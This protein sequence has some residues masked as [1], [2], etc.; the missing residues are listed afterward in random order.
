MS[1]PSLDKGGGLCQ[2]D[3]QCKTFFTY[4]TWILGDHP[5]AIKVRMLVML[6]WVSMITNSIESKEVCLDKEQHHSNWTC[7][8]VQDTHLD[9]GLNGEM[10]LVSISFGEVN[11]H[12]H[13]DL[14]GT[15]PSQLIHLSWLPLLKLMTL[16]CQSRR[17]LPLENQLP[18]DVDVRISPPWN[19]NWQ[20][21]PNVNKRNLWNRIAVWY[22]Y[23]F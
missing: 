5:F 14:H 13:M 6:P 21:V 3:R 7:L 16:G 10:G 12:T 11:P 19:R 22:F 1:V 17:I 2:V 18:S 15:E 9:M 20:P 8:S 23:I 4:T